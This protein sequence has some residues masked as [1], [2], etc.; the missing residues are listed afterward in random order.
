MSTASPLP[1]D[2]LAPTATTLQRLVATPIKAMAFWT[3]IVVPLAYPAL[4]AGGLHGNEL[5]LLGLTLALNV[6]TLVL[7]RDY[8]TD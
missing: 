7:G 4:M 8:N 5:T 6:V 2:R 1:H 3:A